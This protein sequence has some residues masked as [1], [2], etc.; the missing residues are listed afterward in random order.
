[1]LVIPKARWRLYLDESGSPSVRGVTAAQWIIIHQSR[2]T[3]QRPF[4][5][6]LGLGISGRANT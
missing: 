4:W 1:M 3:M 2:L 6:W 5:C